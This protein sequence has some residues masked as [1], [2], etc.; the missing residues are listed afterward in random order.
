MKKL[1]N[2]V[3]LMSEKSGFDKESLPQKFMLLAEEVGELAK[4]VRKTVGTK[5]HKHS[6]EHNPNGEAS[7]VL[8]VLLDICNKL[9]IDLEKEFKKKLKKIANYKQSD[10]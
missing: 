10:T 7:D 8:Y 2:Q 1:Q 6:K 3:R 4:S 5:T 9:N